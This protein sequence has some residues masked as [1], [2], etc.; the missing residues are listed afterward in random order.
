MTFSSFRDKVR[1]VGL[2]SAVILFSLDMYC[3]KNCYRIIIG[4]GRNGPVP[5]KIDETPKGFMV[6]WLSLLLI[7]LFSGLMTL[8]RWQSFLA[9]LAVGFVT[10]LKFYS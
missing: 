10:F 9:L 6:V 8:P 1:W 5:F 3:R 7:T 2:I 4:S